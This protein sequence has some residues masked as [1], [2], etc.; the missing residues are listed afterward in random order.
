MP[1]ISIAHMWLRHVYI[2]PNKLVI[3]STKIME[4]F[5]RIY[6]I[7][8][9][10]GAGVV[11]ALE[12]QKGF[13]AGGIVGYQDVKRFFWFPT[14]SVGISGSALGSD[15]G[16]TTAAGKDAVLTQQLQ[17]DFSTAGVPRR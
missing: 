17:Q 6:Q 10:A 5:C 14:C 1:F 9:Q 7:E 11:Q 4:L 15:G 16:T 13:L 2:I 8:K 12:A 3:Q